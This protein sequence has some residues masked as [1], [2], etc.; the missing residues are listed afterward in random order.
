MTSIPFTAGT[1][2]KGSASVTSGPAAPQY[3]TNN[4]ERNG[5]RFRIAS[6]PL[7]QHIAA[8][9]EQVRTRDSYP[10]PSVEALGRIIDS[11]NALE[12]WTANPEE[13]GENAL[14]S[15]ILEKIFPELSMSRHRCVKLQRNAQMSDLLVPD[16][17]SNK[18]QI[19]QPRPDAIYG[20]SSSITREAF[21]R[22]Q[23]AAHAN[24]YDSSLKG[25]GFQFLAATNCGLRL[26]FLL[27]ECKTSWGLQ[28]LHVA[29]NQCAGG[30]GASLNAV[31]R[32][33]D[34]LRSMDAEPVISD[35]VYGITI[36][37]TEAILYV[38]WK[39]NAV[40]YVIQTVQK[41]DMHSASAVMDFRKQVSNILD[42]AH[43]DRLSQIRVALDTLIRGN[44]N[45]VH[46]TS[47]KRK[48][49]IG[50]DKKCKPSGE[51]S[52]GVHKEKKFKKRR[53]KT[54]QD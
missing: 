15:H 31:A 49:A 12:R 24:I 7:P 8:H 41:F 40:I 1:T 20:Y 19:V 9:I 25:E 22:G 43:D 13:V 27:V 17:K 23:E 2:K 38:S 10:A 4:L 6:D 53:G 28:Q 51:N 42:W 18:L 14:K 45:E 35:F 5:F 54:R 39:E 3:R 48:S 36:N 29:L 46:I 16:D 32:L 21:T 44:D 33:N 34:A 26:P 52:A 30:L 50:H 37:N 11:I 47:P